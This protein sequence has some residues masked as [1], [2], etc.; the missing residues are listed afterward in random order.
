M[1]DLML[2]TTEPIM[3][4][5]PANGTILQPT[6]VDR[7]LFFD[8]VD[9]VLISVGRAPL[10]PAGPQRAIVEVTPED[11]VLQ[12][13]AGAGSGR[14]RCWSGGSSTNCSCSAHRRRG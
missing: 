9:E 2:Q 5:E 3:K 13:L 11:R 14:P 4:A 6:R 1:T 12:I 7:D 10:N 8:L